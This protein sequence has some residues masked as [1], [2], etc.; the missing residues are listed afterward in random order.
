M[1]ALALAACDPKAVLRDVETVL[2]DVALAVLVG[3][4]RPA[5]PDTVDVV[6]STETEP[7]L[8]A[9]DAADDP[10]IWVDPDDPK[11]VWIVGSNKR[12]G[13]EVYDL[14]GKRRSQ[15]DPGRVNNVDL[16]SD[17]VISGE[18]TVV[19]S[20]TNRSTDTIDVWKL[21]PANGA[22]TD[23]L[24]APIPAE[25]DDPY[26][27]CLYH[28]ERTGNLYAIATDKSGGAMQWRLAEAGDG[29]LAG[30]AVRAIHTD[31]QPEGCVADDAN[32]TLFIGEEGVGIWRLG[33]EP[34]DPP[35]DR[36]LV[37]TVR[38][39][40][41]AES[42]TG[43]GPHRLT[44]D[45]EGLALYLPPS[46]GPDA[47][48]LIASSQGN[49]TFVVLDRTPPHTYRG[50]FRVADGDGIDGAGES[51][52]VDAVAMPAGS[53]YP[54]GLLVVQDGHNVNVEGQPENQNFKL[55]S[56]EHVKTALSLPH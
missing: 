46:S 5:P 56:W 50:T 33:A 55:V 1:C 40:G 14:T 39:E 11:R 34:D 10:A 41:E 17:V 28:S 2:R 20:G 48:Y 12:R 36:Q 27:F 31:T 6:A 38:P 23:I 22:L 42:P 3:E 43:T 30:E 18:P 9:S 21:D 24:E 26:G 54:S 49:W 19:V 4:P 52:G 7:V 8:D 35:D 53:A 45:V 47:G 44:D 37:A 51:D 25:L 32:G 29:K 16:R 15:L 13:V